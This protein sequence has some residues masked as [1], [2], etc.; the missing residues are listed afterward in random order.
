MDEL[1]EYFLESWGFPEGS[2]N[3]DLEYPHFYMDDSRFSAFCAAMSRLEDRGFR[4]TRVEQVYKEW[5]RTFKDGYF[6][7]RVVG[8]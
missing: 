1:Y 6:R 7:A 4:G 3:F 5:A 8:A 2:E